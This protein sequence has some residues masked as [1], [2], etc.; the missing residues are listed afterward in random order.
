MRRTRDEEDEG[1]AAEK[2]GSREH[3][4]L[5]N[6]GRGRQPGAS[7]SVEPPAESDTTSF[8]RWMDSSW[9]RD[10]QT[11]DANETERVAMEN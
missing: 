1:K 11:D 2:E 8:Q 3:V 6:P 5:G 4:A 10:A 7:Q 9:I